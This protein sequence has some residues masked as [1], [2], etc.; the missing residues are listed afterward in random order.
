MMHTRNSSYAALLTVVTIAACRDQKPRQYDSI[1]A[2]DDGAL[3]AWH[4]K[5]DR[6]Q[7]GRVDAAGSVL[8]QRELEGRLQYADHPGMV[9]GDGFVA[10]RTQRDQ[11]LMMESVAIEDGALR[12]TT[13]LD[14][15]KEV[16][17]N[18]GLGAR[19]AG[20]S[21]R[22][23]VFAFL[24]RSGGD[25]LVEL[26]SA[27]GRIGSSVP[28]PL[29]QPAPPILFGD[30]AVLHSITG[31]IAISIGGLEASLE[32]HG[33]GCVAN[34]DHWSL[35]RDHEGWFL[36]GR[37]SGVRVSVPLQGTAWLEAC[38][39]YQGRLVV[40]VH[41]D[42]HTVVFQYDDARRV[43]RSWTVSPLV[44][45]PRD[46]GHLPSA[47]PRFLPVV[48]GTSDTRLVMLDLERGMTAW[49]AKADF[50]DLVVRTGDDWVL[51]RSPI[52]PRIA[53][54]GG[55]TGKLRGAARIKRRDVRPISAFNFAGG[56]LW[57][58]STDG[59]PDPLLRIDLRTLAVNATWADA[60]T[61]DELLADIPRESP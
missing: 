56:A 33:L 21:L 34:G 20:F 29:D 31:T 55:G 7:I 48:V 60:A 12:W 49:E 45:N 11:E 17:S 2:I 9:L 27:T 26:D 38:G 51:V 10:L 8:W 44:H 42:G 50:D 1:V 58:L 41:H 23:R 47:L 13:I 40:L 4:D 46:E 54:L 57:V 53:V 24:R 25:D 15:T 19:F 28:V 43:A 6:S 14:K 59:K 35:V 18:A 39:S 32:S 5:R 52:S 3:V 37:P 30:Q 36:L 16:S 61:G 22:S